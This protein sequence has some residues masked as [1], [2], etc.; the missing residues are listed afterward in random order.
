MSDLVVHHLRTTDEYPTTH[1]PT[2]R[3]WSW[4]ALVGAVVLWV[5]GLP[6]FGLTVFLS[7]LTLVLTAIA[8]R[9]SPHDGVFWMGLTLNALLALG[10]AIVLIGLLTGETGIGWE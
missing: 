3:G 4:A 8:W 6:S 5:G 7:P 9:R 10:L 1:A 2:G